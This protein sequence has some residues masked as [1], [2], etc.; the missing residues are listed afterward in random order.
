MTTDRFN[1]HKIKP[2]SH[3]MIKGFILALFIHGVL[4][5]VG[6]KLF[7]K[8]VQYGVQ[9]A[10][11]GIDVDLVAAV[12]QP[13]ADAGK[14]TASTT[15]QQQET[16][17]PPQPDV[18]AAKSIT[19]TTEKRQETVKSMPHP[20][21]GTA[22]MKGKPGYFQ[23]QPPEYS[24]LAKQMHQEG[25]VILWVEIDQKGMPVKVEVEQSSGYQ[26]LD[27]AALKAVRRWRFQPERI[28]NLPVKSSVTIPVRFRLEES[29]RK[30]N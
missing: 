14:S 6:G 13:D 5:F 20:S 8:P 25:L 24:Q 15:E 22:R 3:G 27:R 12:P 4:F 10:N 16:V 28:G 26:L 7:V 18:D 30:S 19:S 21:Q 23:N 11:E 1:Y 17:K 9:S 29:D 2:G